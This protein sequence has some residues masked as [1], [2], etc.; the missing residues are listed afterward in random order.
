MTKTEGYLSKAEEKRLT[1]VAAKHGIYT[2]DEYFGK[3]Q[4]KASRKLGQV[5]NSSPSSISPTLFTPVYADS[6]FLADESPFV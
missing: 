1:K 2:A 5:F 3:Q 4:K 6:V